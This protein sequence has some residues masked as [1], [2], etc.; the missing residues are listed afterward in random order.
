MKLIGLCGKKG[1]GKDFVADQI[2]LV[3]ASAGMRTERAAFADPIKHFCIDV[4]GLQ[5]ELVKGNDRDKNK[6]TKYEWI[7]MPEHIRNKFSASGQVM[8]KYMT[9]RQIMQLF[10]TE[11]GREMF[12]PEIWTNYM[13]RRIKKSKAEYMIITDV[14]FPNEVNLVKKFKGEIWEI[15]GPQRGAPKTADKHLSETA[16]KGSGHVDKIVNNRLDDTVVTIREK[17]KTILGLR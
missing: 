1:V 14:R 8:G 15:C 7:R 4:L 2:L 16:L 6:D 11:I 17:V 9:I 13:E 5:E 3:L 12:D 10:G